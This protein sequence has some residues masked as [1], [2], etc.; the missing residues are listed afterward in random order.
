[1]IL[2]TANMETC[3]PNTAIL[4]HRKTKKRWK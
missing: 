1:M 3:N 4:D 2:L